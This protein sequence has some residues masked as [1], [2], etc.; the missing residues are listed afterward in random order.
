MKFSNELALV[1]I[2]TQSILGLETSNSS[3]NLE[4]F[5]GCHVAI[6]DHELRVRL[7]VEKMFS[8]SALQSRRHN[9]DEDEKKPGGLM[10]GFGSMIV[11]IPLL[12]QILSLPGAIASIK[13][14]LLKSLFVA[15]LALIVMLFNTLRNQRPTEVVLVHQTPPQH[16]DHFYPH[17]HEDYE[18]DDKGWFG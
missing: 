16:H 1:L 14:S 6:Y 3:E 5:P 10:Q 17:F 8:V 2:S 15:K 12:M 11:M 4:L 7:D 18:D 9:H 13:M